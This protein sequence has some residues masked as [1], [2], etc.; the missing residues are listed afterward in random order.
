MFV[1]RCGRI[2]GSPLDSSTSLACHHRG[3]T[4]N[5]LRSSHIREVCELIKESTPTRASEQGQGV[6]GRPHDQLH[7]GSPA[8][9]AFAVGLSP[10]PSRFW[11]FT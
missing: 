5:V 6:P 7:G 8:G 10:R 11:A 4:D 9:A 2:R 1:S 3:H